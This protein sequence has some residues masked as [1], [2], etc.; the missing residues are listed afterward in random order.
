MFCKANWKEKYNLHNNLHYHKV[1][2]TEYIY[3]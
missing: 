1:Y 2:S 3:N